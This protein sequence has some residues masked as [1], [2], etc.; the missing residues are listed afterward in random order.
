MLG[1]HHVTLA[2]RPEVEN[3]RTIKPNDISATLTVPL[4][5]SLG[6]EQVR[7][8]IMVGCAERGWIPK[9]LDGNV[10]EAVLNIRAHT[11]IVTIPYSTGEYKIIYR[12]SESL[13]V[14]DGSLHRNYKNWVKN[15]SSS[16]SKAV[17][18]Q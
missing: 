9:K 16:I 12:S 7:K 8:A 11:V 13:T 14:S 6:L 2:A 3:A 15:L 1:F 18:Q 17:Y 4:S 5:S 10:I